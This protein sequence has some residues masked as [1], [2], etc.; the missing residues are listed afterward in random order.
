MIKCT[1]ILLGIIF[2]VFLLQS[3]ELF[4]WQLFA[5]TPALA[6]KIPWTFITSIFLHADFTHLFFNMFALFM[7][8][9]FLESKI[10]STN[11]L[12]IFFLAGIFGNVGYMLTASNQKIPAIGASGAVYGVMG[13]LA[14]MMPFL[15]VWVM[16]MFPMP[17]ILAAFIWGIMEAFGLFAPGYVAHGAHIFGLIAGILFGLYLRQQESKK[18]RES[19]RF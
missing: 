8:G 10:G 13:A 4:D 12:I 5:F 15:M 18:I 3:S 14:I 11:F 6:F 17:M 7:F 2:I 9:L 1:Y 19:L 16:G